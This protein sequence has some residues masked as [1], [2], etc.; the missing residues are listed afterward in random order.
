MKTRPVQQELTEVSECL[1]TFEGSRNQMLYQREFSKSC[2]QENWRWWKGVPS[3][4]HGQCLKHPKASTGF[5]GKQLS[6]AAEEPRNQ[7]LLDQPPHSGQSSLWHGSVFGCSPN[8]RSVLWSVLLPEVAV[9]EKWM[10]PRVAWQSTPTHSCRVLFNCI[11]VIEVQMVM[12]VFLQ[13]YKRQHYIM[14]IL[15]N[16]PSLR[17]TA[18]SLSQKSMIK[19]QGCWQVGTGKAESFHSYTSW[20]RLYCSSAPCPRNITHRG[21]DEACKGRFAVPPLLLSMLQS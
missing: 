2:N 6:P 4:I 10:T 13:D 7:F 18:E 17:T 3:F 1:K 5:K 11:D 16:T 8:P 15:R 19:M 12:P 9:P 14:P 20:P 21:E